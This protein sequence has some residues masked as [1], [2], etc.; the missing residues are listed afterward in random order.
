M[1]LARLIK[2]GFPEGFRIQRIGI[3]AANSIADR[4]PADI[5]GYFRDNPLTA[6]RLLAES[7]NKRFTP[8]TF[9]EEHGSGFRVGWYS[10]QR[11]SAFG[12]SRV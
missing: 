2:D 12:S 8:S 10:K 7:Y 3:E 1:D 6:E 9:M 5:A 4:P 11:E